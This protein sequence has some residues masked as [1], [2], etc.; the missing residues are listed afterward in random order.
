MEMIRE[1]YTPIFIKFRHPSENLLELFHLRAEATQHGVISE[2]SGQSVT[3]N[4]QRFTLWN[5]LKHCWF[6]PLR[7]KIKVAKVISISVVKYHSLNFVGK[8]LAE[9]AFTVLTQSTGL[10]LLASPAHETSRHSRKVWFDCWIP[11]RH[12]PHS[13]AHFCCVRQPTDRN[14]DRTSDI[15]RNYP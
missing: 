1:D 11:T 13:P 10:L 4:V 15:A 6:S 3:L 8:H 5:Y 9:H 12:R 7:W 14:M 2:D